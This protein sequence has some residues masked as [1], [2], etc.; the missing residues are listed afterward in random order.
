MIVFR[1]VEYDSLFPFCH[2]KFFRVVKYRREH[3]LLFKLK[4]I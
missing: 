4:L 3:N 2:S 1:D